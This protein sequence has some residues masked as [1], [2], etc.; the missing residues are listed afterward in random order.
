MKTYGM[1][2]WQDDFY[3][4][5]TQWYSSEFFAVSPYG[6]GGIVAA[7]N[8]DYIERHY[9]HLF[10]RAWKYLNYGSR[11]IGFNLK[12]LSNALRK[13]II[14]VHENYPCLDDDAIS[15][16]EDEWLDDAVNSWAMGDIA[17]NLGL[18]D[19][20]EGKLYNAIL[21]AL[22]SSDSYAW[23]HPEYDAMWIDVDNPD[24]LKKVRETYEGE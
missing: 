7:A 10:G 13:D 12:R 24:F 4:D 21:D 9:S 14:Y 17:R 6:G 19:Y 20:D 16:I 8:I 3:T 5:H 18:D 2:L 15:R 22:Y 11:V 23:H 1:D